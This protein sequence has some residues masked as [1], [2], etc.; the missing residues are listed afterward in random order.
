MKDRIL[1]VIKAK[2]D[3]LDSH[4]KLRVDTIGIVALK[5]VYNEI[6]EF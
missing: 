6:R 2:I 1:K 5:E 3:V 4:N